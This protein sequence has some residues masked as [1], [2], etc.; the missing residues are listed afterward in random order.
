[1]NAYLRSLLALMM[2]M[3]LLLCGIAA[4][5]SQVHL[6]YLSTE[7][8]RFMYVIWIIGTISCVVSYIFLKPSH[9]W[10]YMVIWA[11]LTLPA[12]FTSLR[13]LQEESPGPEVTPLSAP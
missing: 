7:G 2:S 9:G 5:M 4:A 13:M 8:I 1:M 10:I 11:A 12:L 3:G 6:T